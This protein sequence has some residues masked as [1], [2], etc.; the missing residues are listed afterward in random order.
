MILANTPVISLVVALIAL[1][2][3]IEG[4]KDQLKLSVFAE[5]TKRYG[6]SRRGMPFKTRQ[7]SDA[8]RS[9]DGLDCDERQLVLNAMRNYFNLCSEELFLK[10]EKLIAGKAW[11][12]WFTGMKDC[13]KEPYFSSSW[14]ELS[15]EYGGYPRFC[16]FMQELIDGRAEKS[17]ANKIRDIFRT[18][19]R[20][21]H[22]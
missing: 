2:Y 17:V 8:P 12:I 4:V 13:T 22:V 10:D 19:H 21:L 1:I 5:Y 7:A 16:N 11:K 14:K 3:H 15:T 20:R 9:L 18:V 6:E